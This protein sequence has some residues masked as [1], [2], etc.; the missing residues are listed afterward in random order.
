MLKIAS[1]HQKLV[2]SHAT[3]CPSDPQD[4]T[5]PADTLILDFWPTK[6]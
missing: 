4:G 5:D 6:L 2:E 3:D 1:N